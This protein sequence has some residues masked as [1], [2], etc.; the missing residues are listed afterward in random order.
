MK[1]LIYLSNSKY[2]S[3]KRYIINH[4]VRCTKL[5]LNM[6]EKTVFGEVTWMSSISRYCDTIEELFKVLDGVRMVRV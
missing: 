3:D 6:R 1:I 5:P 4:Y 2:V